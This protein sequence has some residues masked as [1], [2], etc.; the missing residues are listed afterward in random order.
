MSQVLVM[1]WLEG[2]GDVYYLVREP[3]TSH[4]SLPEP[5]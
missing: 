2:R 1:P 3:K 5:A 4:P